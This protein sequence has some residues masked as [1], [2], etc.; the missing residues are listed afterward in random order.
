MQTKTMP[1]GGY[2]YIP[3]VMQYSAGVAA[4][5]GY[6]I[7]RARFF[8]V[9][10]MEEGFERIATLLR[11]IGRPLQAFCACETSHP[12]SIWSDPQNCHHGQTPL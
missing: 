2:R 7:V 11:E 10:P 1:A 9:V 12:N 3:G 4:L 8:D 6:R 5:E